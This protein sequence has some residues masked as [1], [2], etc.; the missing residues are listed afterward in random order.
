MSGL[1]VSAAATPLPATQALY[2][3]QER[4]NSVRRALLKEAKAVD[5]AVAEEQVT[6]QMFRGYSC[7]TIGYMSLRYCCHATDT[8]GADPGLGLRATSRLG[9]Q[10]GV[11]MVGVWGDLCRLTAVT[12]TQLSSALLV[13][14]SRGDFVYDCGIPERCDA[15][16]LQIRLAVRPGSLR[17]QPA[18]P[19]R[20][21]VGCW[22]ALCPTQHRLY[23]H[24][25]PSNSFGSFL[26]SLLHPY[27]S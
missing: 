10:G 15:M 24:A 27:I 26:G 23:I 14:M 8:T 1:Q 7:T 18:S 9:L 5:A 22:I 16:P 13:C 17:Y 3:T 19:S 6:Q 12:H 2:F 4:A 20:L 11:S 21:A 25:C